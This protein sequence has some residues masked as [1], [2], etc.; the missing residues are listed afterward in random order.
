MTSSSSSPPTLTRDDVEAAIKE[1]HYH[2]FPGTTMTVCCLVLQ[3]GFSVIGKSNSLLAE[4]FDAQIGRQAA[5][6]MALEHVWEVEAYLFKQELA[7]A[8]DF[9]GA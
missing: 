6:D 7:D 2:V 1:E 3:N 4:R 8:L 9:R 5:R